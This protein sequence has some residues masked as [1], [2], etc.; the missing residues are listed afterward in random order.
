MKGNSATSFAIAATLP[1]PWAV[2]EPP[3]FAL[4]DAQ[5][6][7]GYSLAAGLQLRQAC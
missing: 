6:V 4:P 5:P 1:S 7:L 3:A 2:L